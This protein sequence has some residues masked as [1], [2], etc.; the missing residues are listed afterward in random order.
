M[1]VPILA[2]AAL[3]LLLALVAVMVAATIGTV[4][5]RSERAESAGTRRRQ[6]LVRVS[7]P[8]SAAEREDAGV[9]RVNAYW[10][11]CSLAVQFADRGTRCWY[12]GGRRGSAPASRSEIVPRVWEETPVY[13]TGIPVARRAPSGSARRASRPTTGCA[14]TTARTVLHRAS[15]VTRAAADA[16]PRDR[17]VPRLGA[18]YPASRPRRA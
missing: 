9:E 1:T 11:R 3:L 6:A 2:F 15:V 7:T 8:L 13:Q 14:A 18:V 16:E 4:N 12:C 10:C 5:A 17:P